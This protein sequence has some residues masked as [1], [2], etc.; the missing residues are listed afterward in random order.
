MPFGFF[1]LFFPS[2]SV[3]LPVKQKA[4]FFKV[5]AQSHEEQKVGVLT[6]LYFFVCTFATRLRWAALE[7]EVSSTS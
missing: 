5:V 1:L 2:F 7:R 4:L 6:F 3:C